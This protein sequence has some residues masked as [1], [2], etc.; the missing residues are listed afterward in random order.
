MFYD[1]IIYVYNINTK[2]KI[3]ST[4]LHLTFLTFQVYIQ[5]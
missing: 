4:S 1:T 2:D 5:N 3:L